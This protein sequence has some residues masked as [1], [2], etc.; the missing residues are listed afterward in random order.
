M[1]GDHPNLVNAGPQGP[2]TPVLL[3]SD[4]EFC[5]VLGAGSASN[6]KET[7]TGC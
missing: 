2:V 7:G 4:V 3:R 6:H 5:T 1:C